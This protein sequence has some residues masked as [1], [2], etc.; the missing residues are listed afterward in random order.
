ML[1]LLFIL[2]FVMV[3]VR[4]LEYD[5]PIKSAASVTIYIMVDQL[6]WLDVDIKNIYIIQTRRLNHV[7]V[8]SNYSTQSAAII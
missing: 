5:W 1:M 6:V 2:L 3:H 7:L 8:N 4:I